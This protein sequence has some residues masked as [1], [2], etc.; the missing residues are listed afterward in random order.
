MLSIKKISHTT[1]YFTLFHPVPVQYSCVTCGQNCLIF[2][3]IS[4]STSRL[5]YAFSSYLLIVI[6]QRIIFVYKAMKYFMMHF[7]KL[8]CMHTPFY[9][10]LATF[11]INS[12]I[13]YYIYMF[14]SIYLFNF[15]VRDNLCLTIKVTTPQLQYITCLSEN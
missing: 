4:I 1:V 7:I 3:H 5:H 9:M 15:V 6:I 10:R 11:K 12:G 8:P 13:E 2:R 14:Y